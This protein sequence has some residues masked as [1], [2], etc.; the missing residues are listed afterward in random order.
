MR[1]RR[2]SIRYGSTEPGFFH[3]PW[4][5]HLPM[6]LARPHWRPPFDCFES[7]DELCVRVELAGIDERELQV[8]LFEQTLVVEGVRRWTGLPGGNCCLRAAQIPYGPF[9]LEVPVGSG[10]R[11]EA[12]EVHYERGLL[13]VRLPK[14]A[15]A[16]E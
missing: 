15:E 13:T 16:S 6:A 10:L 7:A 2:L 8:T 3:L 4:N 5:A 14:K 9:R 1:F 12:L 11:V